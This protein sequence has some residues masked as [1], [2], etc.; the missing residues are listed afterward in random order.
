MVLLGALNDLPALK[1]FPFLWEV[2]WNCLSFCRISQ[3]IRGFKVQL[4]TITSPDPT[5][6]DTHQQQLLKQL[7]FSEL[8]GKRGKKKW[9]WR[10]LA[11]ISP[12]ISRLKQQSNYCL[13]KIFQWA[14]H[15]FI[16]VKEKML[17]F[18]G[19]MLSLYLVTFICN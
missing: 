14:F 5:S 9:K 7:P 3:D 6:P 13:I 8:F 2:S 15:I 19:S 10:I 11:M 1:K 4:K 16:A 18:F 12:Y 17:P